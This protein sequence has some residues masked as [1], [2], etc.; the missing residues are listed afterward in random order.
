M[1]KLVFFTSPIFITES[2]PSEARP[3]RD[4]KSPNAKFRCGV[5]S[6]PCRPIAALHDAV[7]GCRC[8]NEAPQVKLR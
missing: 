7:V 3:F 2:I 5:T 6:R 1:L 8:V 4:Q